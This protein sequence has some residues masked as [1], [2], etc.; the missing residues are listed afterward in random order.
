ML[1]RCCLQ[2]MSETR[3]TTTT[4]PIRIPFRHG[5]LHGTDLGYNNKIVAAKAFAALLAVGDYA[6]Q[7][8]VPPHRLDKDRASKRALS[9]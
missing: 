6:A 3:N 7:C 1:S 4:D 9:S 5:I 2:V 8:L